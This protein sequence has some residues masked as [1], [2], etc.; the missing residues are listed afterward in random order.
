[1]TEDRTPKIE[2][3]PESD[4]NLLE[5]ILGKAPRWTKLQILEIMADGRER[6][7][8]EIIRDL[9][10]KGHQKSYLAIRTAIRDLLRRKAIRR[11]KRGR[12]V[13]DREGMRDYLLALKYFVFK[14]EEGEG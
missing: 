11:T 8:E 4:I 6:D 13:V 3:R 9:E 10:E 14:E 1:M 12:Y 2:Y 5:Y 7:T